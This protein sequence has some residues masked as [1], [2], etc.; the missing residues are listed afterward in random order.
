MRGQRPG[1]VTEFVGMKSYYCSCEKYVKIGKC[2]RI[3]V[4]CQLCENT[5][6]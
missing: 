5:L 6:P 1:T 2:V 4:Q 3:A